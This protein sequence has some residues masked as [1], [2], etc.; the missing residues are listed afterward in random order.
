MSEWADLDADLARQ[1]GQ[2][3]HNCQEWYWTTVSNLPQGP[4][5]SYTANFRASATYRDAQQIILTLVIIEA[6][7]KPA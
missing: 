5:R 1:T 6:A 2:S 3:K 7:E 4:G